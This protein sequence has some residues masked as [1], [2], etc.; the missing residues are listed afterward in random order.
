[1][2]KTSR[3]RALIPVL[4]FFHFS[5]AAEG[6]QASPGDL[7]GLAKHAEVRFYEIAASRA[8]EAVYAN[9]RSGHPLW[10]AD[11]ARLRRNLGGQGEGLSFYLSGVAQ[12]VLLDRLSPGWK[13]RAF[14]DKANLEDCLRAAIL[15]D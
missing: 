3:V 7:E 15:S 13:A 2:K 8:S 6:G 14:E 12:A 5:A 9:Y 4:F 1:M 10:P 11:L